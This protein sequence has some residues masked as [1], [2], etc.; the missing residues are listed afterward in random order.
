MAVASI[1]TAC[2]PKNDPALGPGA[3]NNEEKGGDSEVIDWSLLGTLPEGCLTVAEAREIAGKLASGESTAEFYYVRGYIKK[4]HSKN[5][6]G[7]TQYGNASFYMVDE[8]DASDDF[9]AYQVYALN[10]EKFTS[11]DQ[12]A[13]GDLVVIKAKLTNYNGTL[14]TTGKGEGFIIVSTNPNLKGGGSSEQKDPEGVVGNGTQANPYTVADL[15]LLN[16]AKT[17][18]FYV[19]GFIVGQVKAGV[20]SWSAE[21]TQV[22]PPFE[23]ESGDNTNI[24]I[25]A[26]AGATDMAVMVPVQLPAGFLRDALNLVKNPSNLGAEVVLYGSLEKYFG[27]PGVKSITKA[28]ING[29]EIVLENGEAP[30]ATKATVAEFNAAPVN[31]TVPGVYYE[32]TGTIKS[33]TSTKYGNFTL[34]DA[35]GSVVVYGL[36]KDYM[37]LKTATT[38]N[39]DQSFSQL[40]LAEGDNITI[41]GCRIDYKDAPEVIGAYFVKKN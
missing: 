38:A 10:S 13:V 26:A 36:T 9:L 35:T 39:N 34:E 33:L 16:G 40:N 17:G 30:T 6:D 8:K 37:I 4:L 22:L 27:K 25:A 31:T 23:S 21:T 14:E 29:K 5:T 24:L 28:W 12:V 20:T 32:L 41:R 7:I 19:K 3:G 15:I 1:F 2:E 11:V 18:N